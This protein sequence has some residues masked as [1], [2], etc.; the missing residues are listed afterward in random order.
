M[1]SVSWWRRRPV[2]RRSLCFHR[3]HRPGP[4]PSLARTLPS[5]GRS[6]DASCGRLN[7]RTR[8]AAHNYM[9]TMLTRPLFPVVRSRLALVLGHVG[10]SLEASVEKDAGGGGVVEGRRGLGGV[11]AVAEGEE[12]KAVGAD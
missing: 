2:G 8:L 5:H 9:P 10:V 4:H 12:G 11:R 1:V 6:S 3:S 7:S